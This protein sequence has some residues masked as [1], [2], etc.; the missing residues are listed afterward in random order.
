MKLRLVLNTPSFLDLD[1]QQTE[2]LNLQE[3][4]TPDPDLNGR[5]NATPGVFIL[6]STNGSGLK[7][8]KIK[9]CRSV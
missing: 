2:M 5:L 8:C 3:T 4:K 7:V 1:P 9:F 6:M